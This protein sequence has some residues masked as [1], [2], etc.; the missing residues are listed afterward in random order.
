LFIFIQSSFPSPIREPDVPF[1]DKY[2]HFIAYAVLGILFLRAYR[3]LRWGD[4]KIKV[5]LLSI[6]SAG[7]YGISDEIHQY[8]VPGR[9]A[10]ILDAMVNF[11]GAVCGAFC[12]QYAA[13]TRSTFSL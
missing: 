5:F 6:L 10:D 2:L 3:T 4:D 8:F 9:N 13:K 1:F 12:Y 7:L 11:F